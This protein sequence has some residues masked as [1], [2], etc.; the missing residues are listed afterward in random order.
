MKNRDGHEFVIIQLSVWWLQWLPQ[1]RADEILA[2]GGKRKGRT[3][4]ACLMRWR[5]TAGSWSQAAHQLRAGF[6]PSICGFIGEGNGTPPQ[7][8][9]LENP[10]DGEAW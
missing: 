6:F 8:S 9:C 10:M 3:A 5:E 4:Y 2:H 1:G 7:Y